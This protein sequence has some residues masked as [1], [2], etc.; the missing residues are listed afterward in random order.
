MNAA[1]LPTAAELQRSPRVRAEDGFV[2]L[3]LPLKSR[4][5]SSD[6]QDIEVFLTPQTAEQIAEWLRKYAQKIG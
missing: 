4:H 1:R 5:D 6:L 3:H 2:I